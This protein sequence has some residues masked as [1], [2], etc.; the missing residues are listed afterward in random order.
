MRWHLGRK[1]AGYA[2]ERAHQA[3]AEESAWVTA[4]DAAYAKRAVGAAL[5]PANRTGTSQGDISK[6]ERGV[7]APTTLTLLNLVR[8]LG[9]ELTLTVPAE[10]VTEMDGDVQRDAEPLSLVLA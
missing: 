2:A 9:A 7:V 4:F 1:F 6:I 5:E 10:A 3:S 8:A